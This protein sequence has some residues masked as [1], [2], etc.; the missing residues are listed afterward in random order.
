M[1]IKVKSLNPIKGEADSMA[2]EIDEDN[3]VVD[4]MKCVPGNQ[5]IVT[6]YP[7]IY[8]R[9]RKD[10]YGG[11]EFVCKYCRKIHRHGRGEG[12]RVAHCHNEKS[13]YEQTGYVLKLSDEEKSKCPEHYPK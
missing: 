11:I 13:G 10:F 6:I 4:M 7:T 5:F 8:G 9:L 1:E 12:H 3:E 2:G